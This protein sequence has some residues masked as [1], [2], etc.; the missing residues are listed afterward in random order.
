MSHTGSSILPERSTT[1]AKESMSSLTRYAL[2]LQ[3]RHKVKIL[4]YAR[5]KRACLVFTFG[6][7]GMAFLEE[8]IYGEFGGTISPFGPLPNLFAT[9]NDHK[10]F[11]RPEMMLKDR[12]VNL[13]EHNA[14]YDEQVRKGLEPKGDKLTLWM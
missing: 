4:L 13:Y 5:T 2:G 6:V 1:C 12:L 3:Q 11:N 7:I 10:N 9:L 14:Y 8:I